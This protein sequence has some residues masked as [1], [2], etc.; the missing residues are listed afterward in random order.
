MKHE[1]HLPGR[2]AVLAA[3]A[4]VLLMPL[5]GRAATGVQRRSEPLFGSPAD[6]L[7]ALGPDARAQAHA[8]MAAVF[9]GLRTMNQ[10]WNAWKPGELSTL[11]QAL[12]SGRMAR[13]SPALASMIRSAARLEIRS[14]G[15]FNPAIG[16]LVAEWGFHDDAL[17]PG[18]RPRAGTLVAWQHRAPSLAQLQWRGGEVRSANPWLQIDLGAYA[19][20]VAADWALDR[21]AARGVRDAVVNLGGNLA[22]MG[23]A[24]GRPWRVGIRDP[25]QA[26]PQAVLGSLL[27]HGREAVVT[28]GTY[29]RWRL[30]DGEACT[31]IIDPRKGTPA[32]DLVS[33]TVVHASAALADAA[34][35]ALLVAGPARWA[36]V[37]QGLGVNQVLVIDRNGSGQVTPG[38]APR[39]ELHSA[40]WR[41]RIRTA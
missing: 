37:A 11:N 36:A 35:T 29:E 10:R 16:G 1:C 17:E 32:N 18:T 41:G 9:A 15:H 3:G 6:V 24:P 20:G 23:Q 22:A 13:P 39:L 33:V 25:E 40:A 38:L 31:H 30:L 5:D 27:T 4:G 19:K 7:L 34:A 26:D 2:R 28:S 14:D 21:L 8:A 12:R